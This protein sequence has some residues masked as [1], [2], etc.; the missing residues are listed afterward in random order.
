MN[1]ELKMRRF[2]FLCFMFF[3]VSATA[4]SVSDSL[5]AELNALLERK[6]GFVHA[7]EEEIARYKAGLSR[8]ADPFGQRSHP[9]GTTAGR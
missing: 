5:I 4:Q 1:L 9:F 3:A 2:L 7:K 6:E 8:T